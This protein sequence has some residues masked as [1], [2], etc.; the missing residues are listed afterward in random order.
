MAAISKTNVAYST[1][2]GG[3]GTTA[4]AQS[5]VQSGVAGRCDYIMLRGFRGSAAYVNVANWSWNGVVPSDHNL[6]YADVVVPFS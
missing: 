1:F 3:N 6:V 2:N 4:P 5:P